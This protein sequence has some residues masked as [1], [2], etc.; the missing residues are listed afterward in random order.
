[1]RGLASVAHRRP[2]LNPDAVRL[3][4]AKNVSEPSGR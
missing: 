1:M 2:M 3:Y 4:V